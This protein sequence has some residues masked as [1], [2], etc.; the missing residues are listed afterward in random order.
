MPSILSL[1]MI[2]FRK[3]T[4][5]VTLILSILILSACNLPARQVN[6]L[7]AP[8]QTD[9]IQPE[10]SPTPANLCANQ[11]FPGTLGDAWEYSGSNTALGAYTRTDAVTSSSAEAFSV[12]TT[13]SSLTYRVN[14]ACTSAGLIA[15]DP[16][17][18]YAG[19]LLSAPNAPISVRLSSNSGLTLPPVINPG[20]TWQQSADFEASSPDFN[21]SGR[22][23]FNY[24]AVGYE[25]VTV[26][27]GAFNALRV[28]ATIRIEVS[29]FRILAGTYTTSTWMVPEIGVVKSEGISHIPG[30]EFT[31]G[32]QLTK[33]S[34]TP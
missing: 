14:Y 27:F 16:V 18:Q 28:D 17:Q 21:L 13:I 23:V 32:I 15:N 5:I 6:Q 11:Y 4:F 20:D 30:V 10:A 31:D 19:A 22:F 26:P 24:T 1:E 8:T 7:K 33:Y 25:N 3:L 9:L 12:D 2:M 29:G 34:S